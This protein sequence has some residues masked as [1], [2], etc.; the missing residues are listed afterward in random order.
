MHQLFEISSIT[1]FFCA[2]CAFLWLK[3]PFNQ[4]NQRV[5]ISSCLR[6]LRGEKIS[7][8]SVNPWLINY[9]YAFGI[10][11]LVK[12][13]LQISPFYA[14]RTQFPKKSNERKLC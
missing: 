14:K 13:S 1:L 8:I 11:T 5:N 7:E 10:F 12:M 9:L 2:F 3:N 6:A 4:R